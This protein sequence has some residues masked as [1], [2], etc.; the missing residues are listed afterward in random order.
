MRCHKLNMF[1]KG[2]K[3]SAWHDDNSSFLLSLFVFI[4]ILFFSFLFCVALSSLLGTYPLFSKVKWQC[5][6]S[7]KR[8]TSTHTYI[9]TY[10]YITQR[11]ASLHLSTNVLMYTYICQYNK[12]FIVKYLILLF[13]VV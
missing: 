1:M 11:K 8:H 12:I 3:V 10:V 7:F 9:H 13:F 2:I 6:Q 5:Q 4:F